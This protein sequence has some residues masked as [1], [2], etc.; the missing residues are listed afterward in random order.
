MTWWDKQL[1]EKIR[2]SN[3]TLLLYKRYIDD[4]DMVTET[5]KEDINKYAES[6]EG[7][8]PEPDAV[9]MRKI[10]EMG[11]EIH[12]SIQLETDYPSKNPDKK[13]PLLDVKIWTEKRRNNKRQKKM[14]R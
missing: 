13:M 10:K 14:K 4:I 11:N 2:D 1:K 6:I 8:T 9:I 5:S 7:E 3:I 12:P